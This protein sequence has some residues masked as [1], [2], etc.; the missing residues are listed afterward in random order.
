MSKLQVFFDLCN[1]KFFTTKLKLFRLCPLPLP[2]GFPP[3]HTA[4][5]KGTVGRELKGRDSHHIFHFELIEYNTNVIDNFKTSTNILSALSC[6]FFAFVLLHLPASHNGIRFINW[7]YNIS[8]VIL[9]LI[10][11]LKHCLS[12][13]DCRLLRRYF[14]IPRDVFMRTIQPQAK[15]VIIVMDHGNSLSATQMHI[16]KAITKH[17]IAS[18]SDEDKVRDYRIS[19]HGHKFYE[20]STHVPSLFFIGILASIV[21]CGRKILSAVGNTAVLNSLSDTETHFTPCK[22]FWSG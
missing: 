21:N 8:K 20:R 9:C 19:K 2:L 18:F 10:Y 22:S 16:A 12:T 6:F 17:L 5:K 4:P 11:L 1:W 13:R 7:C 15:H 3:V 14:L